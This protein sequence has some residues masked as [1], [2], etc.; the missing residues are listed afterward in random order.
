MGNVCRNLL[1]DLRLWDSALHCL[2]MSP[3]GHGGFLDPVDSACPGLVQSRGWGGTM[4]LSFRKCISNSIIPFH[5]FLY[6][7]KLTWNQTAENKSENKTT[8]KPSCSGIGEPLFL[9][10]RDFPSWD[11]FRDLSW[12]QWHCLNIPLFSVFPRL[13]FLISYLPLSQF[14]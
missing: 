13:F 7:T 12:D 5:G 11:P 4:Y 3:L 10:P 2:P 6:L 9:V 1:P 14:C 8:S